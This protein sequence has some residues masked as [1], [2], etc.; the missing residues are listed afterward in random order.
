MTVSPKRRWWVGAVLVTGLIAGAVRVAA[1]QAETVAPGGNY[2]DAIRWYERAAAAGDQRAQY[3][4]AI[5]L[6]RGVG[7]PA[8]LP[9]AAEWYRRAAED[10]H[11]EAQFMLASLL[12]TG[13]G[14]AR[15]PTQAA[16][17]FESAGRLGLPEAQ[18][19][20]G[21]MLLNGNG[22]ERDPVEAFAWLTLA[23]HAGLGNAE[24]LR[25]ELL[26]VL[27]EDGLEDGGRR[28]VSELIDE[29]ENP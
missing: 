23:V 12:L 29:I 8:N 9:R 13:R 1:A 11:R 10:G 27:T 28:R 5:R 2:G 22:P 26:Q 18:Y 25:E 20:Y 14:V 16:G 15:D 19:N 4:L 6:E 21:V 24:R 3:L 17:W 7:G